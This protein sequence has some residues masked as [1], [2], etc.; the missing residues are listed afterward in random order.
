M[1]N[2]SKALVMAGGILI[3]LLIIGALLLM[4]NNLSS[5]QNSNQQNIKD[6]QI[7]EFNNKFTT[8]IRDDVRG[9][10]LYSLLNSVIDYNRRKTI[11]GDEGAIQI[12][13]MPME[14]KFI[15]DKNDR[16]KLSIDDINRI[17][18]KDE[19]VINKSNN[20]FEQD[21]NN[22]MKNVITKEYTENILNSLTIAITK[23]F[24]P[25]NASD[26]E[27]DKAVEAFKS[28]TGLNV[29]YSDLEKGKPIREKVYKYYEYVQ[30]KR[31]H[32]D[33]I[34]SKYD[35]NTGRIT[36]LEFKFNGTIQ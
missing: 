12:A 30:F 1:E 22:S 35:N 21:V 27:K 31:A 24:L 2:A 28:I 5:Y 29:N 8:Y 33:C 25:E 34:D 11:E 9:N 14:V 10:E 36:Y 13:Y 7:V 15:I 18:L 4:F 6:E 19:Y 3:A 16:K 17:I 26:E 20:S 32:F 23:I